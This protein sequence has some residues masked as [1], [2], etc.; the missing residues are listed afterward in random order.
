MSPNTAIILLSCVAGALLLA[1][2]FL[3]LGRRRS[4]EQMERARRLHLSARG[5]LGD[6]EII[7]FDRGRLRKPGA[8][9]RRNLDRLHRSLAKIADEPAIRTGLRAQWRILQAA[10]ESRAP[11]P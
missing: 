4:P 8:W 9:G 10:Y 5:R 1:A 11:R 3:L 2:G 7:D 6:A